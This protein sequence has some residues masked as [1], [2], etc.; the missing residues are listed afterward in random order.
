M[1]P[2]I[3]SA[4]VMAN[5]S[6]GRASVPSWVLSK[7]REMV[8]D[9]LSVSHIAGQLTALGH[10]CTARQVKRWKEVNK[11]GRRTLKVT[12]AELD[13]TVSG[14]IASGQAGPTEGY[15]W[16]HSAVNV[17]LAPKRVGVE[18]VRRS[19]KR[20]DPAA[21]AKRT[22]YIERRLIRRVYTADYYG[23]NGHVD[24]N[25]KATLPGGVRLYTYGHV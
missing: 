10:R 17:A 9:G 4:I 23:Q 14:M 6:G 1:P 19:I 22:D 25:C 20:L 8:D 7:V 15:R 18:R 3:I 16:L 12:D 24:F 13:T 11:I 5:H 21:V 2:E